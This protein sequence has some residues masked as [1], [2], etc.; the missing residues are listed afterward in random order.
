MILRY[1]LSLPLMLAQFFGHL[2]KLINLFNISNHK[3]IIYQNQKRNKNWL[4]IF[5]MTREIEP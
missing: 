1:D 2:V 5:G 4:N 3:K